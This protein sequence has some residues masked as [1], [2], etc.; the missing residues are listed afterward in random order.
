MMWRTA[1]EVSWAP[2]SAIAFLLPFLLPFFLSLFL[3]LAPAGGDPANGPGGKLDSRLC[4][5][6]PAFLLPSVLSLFLS[7]LLFQGSRLLFKAKIL[8][9]ALGKDALPLPLLPSICLPSSHLP[10]N[11]LPSLLSFFPS[12]FL[13]FCC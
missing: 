5:C 8:G 1:L 4:N 13:S 9:R 12:F 6:V 2:V 3:L 11:C 7:R 10:S